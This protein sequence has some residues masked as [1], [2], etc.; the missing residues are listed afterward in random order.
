MT[1][2]NTFRM[3]KLS[4]PM[5]SLYEN[6]FN[7]LQL[8]LEK[9]ACERDEH[10]MDNNSDFYTLKG[11]QLIDNSQITSSMEDYLEMICRITKNQDIVR[12]N[13]LADR[14]HV[15]PSSASKMVGNLKYYELVVFEKYGYIKPTAKGR[16]IGEYLLFRHKVLNEFLCLINQTDDETEQVEKIEHFLDEKTIRNIEKIVLSA[17]KNNKLHESC[18]GRAGHEVCRDTDGEEAA[19]KEP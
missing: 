1:P 13:E 17:N 16:A 10:N 15:K 4:F 6:V 3:G 7:V 2:R 19:H 18:A 5:L 12:I 14:L 11:Y 9:T 8:W